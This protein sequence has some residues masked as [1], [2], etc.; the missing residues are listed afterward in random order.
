MSDGKRVLSLDVLRGIAILLVIF[1]HNP[2]F[3]EVRP[4]P[5]AVF[6]LFN[7]IGWM[8]VDLFFVLS[9]FLVGG[10]LLKELEASGR[11]RAGRF[12][13]RR[14]FKIWPTYYFFLVLYCSFQIAYYGRSASDVASHFWPNFLHVQNY[15]SSTADLGW[16]WSLG[17][18]E[19]FYLALPLLL[20]AYFARGERHVPLTGIRLVALPVGVLGV[21]LALRGLTFLVADHQRSPFVLVFPSH[22]RFDSLFTGVFLAYLVTFR[23]DLVERLRPSRFLLLVAAIGL[24][25]VP[26]ASS[27]DAQL[28]LYPFGQ[29][30]LTIGFGAAVLYAHLVST[31]PASSSRMPK[32][33]AW[34]VHGFAAVL[35]RIGVFS[36]SIYVWH[37]FW[38]KPIANRLTAMLGLRPAQPGI[39]FFYELVY[40]TVP[41]VVGAIA[42]H[43][44]EAPFL[45]LREKWVPR[46]KA[47]PLRSATASAPSSGAAA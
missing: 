1:V 47:E 41:I 2:V 43:L 28:F 38:C 23:P 18:E 19:H 11:I 34:L 22:L 33:L 3:P 8:G 37:G 16:L 42:F 35:A 31:S 24:S 7:R 13:V 40:W 45:R 15:F 25:L 14:G 39:G 32:S 46:T 4:W 12:I 30:I 6:P 36:Y 5:Y 9:G 10:L 26:S 17:V 21:G 29:T 27:G 44:V 20:S